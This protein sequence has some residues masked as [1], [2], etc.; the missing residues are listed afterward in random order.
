LK[1][2]W[3]VQDIL[4]NFRVVQDILK[5]FRSGGL[6]SWVVQDIFIFFRGGTRY[7]YIFAPTAKIP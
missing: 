5:N 2:H 7:F 4:K 3:V 6:L 1:E